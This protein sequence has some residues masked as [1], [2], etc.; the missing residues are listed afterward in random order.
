MMS[1]KKFRELELKASIAPSQ[2]QWPTEHSHWQFLGAVVDEARSR[3][4]KF[5][6]ALDEI[7]ADPRLTREGKNQE[8]K[9]AAEKAMAAM[10]ASN[11]LVRARDSVAAIM[12]KWEAKVR[13]LVKPAARE[14]EAVLHGEIRRHVASL[15]GGPERMSFLEKHAGD[16]VLAAALLE[17]PQFQWRLTP[18]NPFRSTFGLELE[19]RTR[20][21][22]SRSPPAHR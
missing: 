18:R 1:N 16:P 7:E 12:A 5:L 6:E 17:A 19:P 3:V 9:A 22:D 20:A 4:G 15:K 10:K 21:R 13:S 14:A 8:R 11:S 2:S